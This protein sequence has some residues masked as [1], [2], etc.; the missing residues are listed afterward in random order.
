MDRTLETDGPA[1]YLST[2]TSSFPEASYGLLTK[3]L[4]LFLFFHKGDF[5][6]SLVRPLTG[7]MEFAISLE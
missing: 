6:F 2:F 7:I 1:N 4:F 5:R 3:G